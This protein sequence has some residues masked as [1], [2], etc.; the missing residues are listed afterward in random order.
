MKRFITKSIHAKRILLLIA[1]AGLLN[2]AS[3]AR[4]PQRGYRG[5]IEWS[6]NV[7]S[8]R[9]ANLVSATSLSFYRQTQLYTGVTTSHG[10]QINPMFFVGAGLGMERHTTSDNWIAPV[11]VQSR[12]DLLLGRFTPFAD[13]RL[14]ANLSSGTG[15]YF[16]PSIGY[17]FNWGRKTGINIG[18][19]LTLA[20]YKAHHYEGTWQGPDSFELQYIGTKRHVRAYFSFRLGLD[21]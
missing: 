2:S 4:Q 16:S 13:I 21:F 1:A 20:G 11:F 17:R 7:R 5:F 8:E 6:N 10:Y 15:I 18:A 19:G 3:H 9:Y 12:L 14:G